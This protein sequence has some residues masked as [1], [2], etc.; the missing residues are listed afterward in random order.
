MEAGR[1]G[2]C[3][4]TNR[5]MGKAQGVGPGQGPGQVWR[6]ERGRTCGPDRTVETSAVTDQNA[7]GGMRK[8]S[9]VRWR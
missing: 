5:A 4:Q 6:A 9:G 7:G 8:V 1:C 2:A 3:G